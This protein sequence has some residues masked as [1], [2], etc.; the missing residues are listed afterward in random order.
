M[1]AL[2]HVIRAAWARMQPGGPSV[3]LDV[4]DYR[5]EKQE[6]LVQMVRTAIERVRNTN[7][8]EAL[9]PMSAY[10]RRLVHTELAAYTDVGS[11]SVGQE[12]YRR[13]VIK[14]Q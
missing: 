2:E 5:R 3:T 6:E 11:E 7:R 8:P 1:K 10:D 14:P 9:P 13:V 4:N 12:P